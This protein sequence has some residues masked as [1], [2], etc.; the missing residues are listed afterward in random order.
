M[1]TKIEF[2]S[3]IKTYIN[4]K[5]NS[6]RIAEA[7]AYVVLEP[8]LFG[9]QIE[10]KK[11]GNYIFIKSSLENKAQLKGLNFSNVDISAANHKHIKEDEMLTMVPENLLYN[12]EFN[13]LLSMVKEDIW[14]ILQTSINI[15][16]NS[17]DDLS[18]KRLV[19]INA[20]MELTGKERPIKR[21]RR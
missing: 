1:L 14:D 13:I 16:S 20:F 15:G 8:F 3:K 18:S 21:T 9:S 5:K 6:S 12:K 11:L 7:N 2:I 10:N 4:I 17:S 19:T